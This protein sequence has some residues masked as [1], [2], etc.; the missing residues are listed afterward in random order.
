MK[1]FDLVNISERYMEIINPSTPEKILTVGKIL[2]IG[3]DSRI[4]DFGCGY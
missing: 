3:Q 2:G 4:I 1:F